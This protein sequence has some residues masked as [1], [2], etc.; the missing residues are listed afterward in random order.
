M[1]PFSETKTWE[2]KAD[3]RGLESGEE[4]ALIDDFVKERGKRKAAVD[5]EGFERECLERE[6]PGE[7]VA[8][9]K[10]CRDCVI[11]RGKV[12]SSELRKWLP[13]DPGPKTAS[14]FGSGW[15]G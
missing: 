2:V 15:I 4:E 7:R 10:S 6:M 11:V 5:G 9:V 1:E 12:G 3:D 8:E 13:E 14:S